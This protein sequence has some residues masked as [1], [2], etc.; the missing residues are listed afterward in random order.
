M[1]R[2]LL[3][4][5][6]AALLCALLPASAAARGCL[7]R[8]AVQVEKVA[9]VREY[10]VRGRDEGGRLNAYTY[11]VCAD[12]SGRRVGLAFR[13]L[14]PRGWAGES[15]DVIRFAGNFVAAGISEADSYYRTRT[16][17]RRIDLSTGKRQ[18]TRVNCKNCS[19]PLEDGRVRITDLVLSRLGN[20]AYIAE[21]TVRSDRYVVG[22]RD[23][24]GPANLA[25]G[26]DIDTHSL[27]LK[28][29][30]VYWLAG[31]RAQDEDLF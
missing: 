17:V 15:V 2:S 5:A 16:Y 24:R 22:R 31:G 27:A 29:T 21:D 23:S 11:A 8:G 19:A 25:R 1:H 28:T 14:S 6:S 30:T 26:G 10:Y 13:G 18:D 20:L 7:P 4:I 12:R 3:L 9:G